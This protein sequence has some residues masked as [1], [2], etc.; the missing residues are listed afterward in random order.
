MS[1]PLNNMILIHAGKKCDMITFNS[2][3]HAIG[4]AFGFPSIEEKLKIRSLP[5]RIFHLRVDL[6]PL[7]DQ[8]LKSFG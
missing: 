7:P 6:L 8:L 1:F 2:A 4:D 5:E 3:C